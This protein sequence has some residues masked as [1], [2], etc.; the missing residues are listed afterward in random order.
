M[1]MTS[2]VLHKMSPYKFT[3][4]SELLTASII[5]ALMMEAVSICETLVTFCETTRLNIPDDSQ[6]S[7]SFLMIWSSGGL[8]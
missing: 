7:F 8:L 3:D 2:D 5:R 6:L 4:V 1:K